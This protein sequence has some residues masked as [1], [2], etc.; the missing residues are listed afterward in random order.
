MGLQRD[1]ENMIVVPVVAKNFISNNGVGSN[2][3]TDESKS[4]SRQSPFSSFD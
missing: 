2:Y 3:P 4:T 1:V